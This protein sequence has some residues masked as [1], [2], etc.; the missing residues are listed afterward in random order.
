MKY[1]LSS[2]YH[3]ALVANSTAAAFTAKVPTTTK[4]TGVGVFD[5]FDRDVGVGM[6]PYVPK[7]IEMQPWGKDTANDT[8]DMRLWGWREVSLREPTGAGLWVPKLLLELNCILGN[9]AQSE[10][11][12][13]MADAITIAVGAVA[14]DGG[15]ITTA[16]DTP[17]SIL[18]HLRGSRLI[19]FDFDLAG[20]VPGTEMNCWWAAFDQS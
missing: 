10:T 13:F 9:I 18:A 14:A 11:G 19:E 8:F 20:G 16:N 5:L 12:T 17:A 3:R 4:P 15:V 7:F 6:E 1:S 2:S